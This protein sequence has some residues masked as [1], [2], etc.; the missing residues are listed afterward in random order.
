MD[1]LSLLAKD[2]NYS[3]ITLTETWLN[4]D[5]DLAILDLEGYSLF[6]FDR[7]GPG[8]GVAIFVNSELVVERLHQFDCTVTESLWI[9]IV[10]K[11]GS[12]IIGVCYCPQT[13][14]EC[15]VNAALFVEYLSDTFNTIADSTN[16]G[17][18]LMGDFNAKDPRWGST[19]GSNALGHRLF[20]F[21]SDN[22]L[23]Q[24]IDEPTRY[25][26]TSNS[27][28]DLIIT[29]VPD[30]IHH[31]GI[32][33]PLFESCDHCIIEAQLALPSRS[34]RSYFREF[35]NT[36]NVDWNI[37]N[38]N[39]R[40]APWDTCYS[41]SQEPEIV[42]DR[43]ISLFHDTIKANIP[44]KRTK[45]SERDQPW[46]TPLIKHLRN[47]RRRLFRKAKSSNSK[48]F[49]DLYHSTDAEYHDNI[50]IAKRDYLKGIADSLNDPNM[51]KKKWWKLLKNVYGKSGSSQN[52]IPDLM[53]NGTVID[54][55]SHKCQSLNDYFIEQSTLDDS[56]ATL[57]NLQYSSPSFDTPFITSSF[58]SKHLKSLDCSKSTGPD[59]ISNEI[60]SHIS[61]GISIALATFFNYSIRMGTFPKCWKIANV[62][63]IYKKGNKSHLNS[64]R[65]ISLLNC[66]AKV[67]ESCI[68]FA[69]RQ[70]LE[71]YDLIYKQ[72]SGF[73]PGDS[74]CNQLI[75][76][77]DIILSAL[78]QGEEVHAVFLDISKAFDRIWH[79][80]LIHK[81]KF[82]F[83]IEGP[84]LR[85]FQ[86]YLSG[87]KQRVVLNG[88]SSPLRTIFAGVPQ[89][90]VLGPILF[91]MYINDLSREVLT[92]LFL[93][94]DD[95]TLV[96]KFRDY[97]ISTSLINHD[98]QAIEK[99]AKIWLMD[100]NPTKTESMTFS[101]KREPS[102]ANG[103]LFFDSLI[104][105][106]FTHKHL[107]VTFHH[108]MSW[109]DH[110]DLISNKCMSRLNILRRIRKKIP[111]DALLVLYS[112][113]IRSLM[114]Y[115]I[116]LFSH[117]DIA[118]FEKVQY[119]ACLVICGA[120]RL[121]SYEKLLIELGLQK[122]CQ[123]A[124]F[125][126]VSLFYKIVNGV[127]STHFSNFVIGKCHR[128][129]GTPHAL[130]NVSH[131]QPPRCQTSRYSNSF[132]PSACRLWNSLPNLLVSKPTVSSFKSNYKRLFFERSGRSYNIGS[133]EYN[134]L[135]TRFRLG[136]TT[137]NNDLY[138]R[139]L[140]ISPVCSCGLDVEDYFHYFLACP[141]YVSIRPRL[142][143]SIDTLFEENELDITLFTNEDI[144]R[145]F[146][147]G[148]I[149]PLT[150]CNAQLFTSVQEF[151]RL[152]SRF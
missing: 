99:W 80:G 85:W 100:F 81:L 118:K 19:R 35:Y 141:N 121:S 87:R 127:T 13:I 54:D 47:L 147:F 98:L 148:F 144:I 135:H 58:I 84:M 79:R 32:L 27:T 50:A 128:N 134:T 96:N 149:D 71:K 69:I 76:I 102:K 43:W 30:M 51:C 136:F 112:T 110:I 101:A 10:T 88:Y 86:S 8:G 132:I 65:P 73:I 68:A 38:D 103:F 28:L 17:F 75:V 46:V 104:T 120:L 142:L 3:V 70:H 49:W 126:K 2:R 5:S 34:K 129:L 117:L 72:Q 114:E 109:S 14:S 62:I 97:N 91:I 139:G 18:I 125:L 21:I 82:Y 52:S 92:N 93:F 94:A 53:V 44:L 106:V 56:N 130:R 55:I 42:L 78:E 33:P 39:L 12:L 115:G 37:V 24:L 150:K 124:D 23:Q 122:I 4:N 66:L 36:K 25:S 95:S 133:R 20:D 152:S 77:N 145:H 131:L 29:N 107:G 7:Q 48:R 137:L 1:A 11:S 74:T 140:S 61:D 146:I 64:Y 67:F 108:R 123:R 116:V 83:G 63:P 15:A 89:G 6:R 9:K 138:R 151:I 22:G 40:S 111:R 59:G 119:Q 143:R 57:P 105:E 16:L 41:A 60:L 31:S 45:I 113:M 26:A 90:S